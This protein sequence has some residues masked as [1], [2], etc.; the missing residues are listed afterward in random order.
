MTA[1][2]INAEIA[3]LCGWTCGK[4]MRESLSGP[5][6]PWFPPYF[7]SLDACAE[8]EAGLDKET[9]DVRSLYWDYVA[10]VAANKATWPDPFETDWACLR[11]TPAQRCEAF[12]RLKGRWKEAAP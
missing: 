10:L 8:F 7:T 1:A 11:A 4:P 12:L 5:D 3:K 6:R 9:V 2:E